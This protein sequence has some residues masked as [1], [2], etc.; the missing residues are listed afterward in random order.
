[1]RYADRQSLPPS[2]GARSAAARARRHA[3]PG[4]WLAGEAGAIGAVGAAGVVAAGGVLGVGGAA[5][6]SQPPSTTSA[7]ATVKAAMSRD[8]V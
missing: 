3:K 1:M 8:S 5:R 2:G 7:A 4:H 6:R